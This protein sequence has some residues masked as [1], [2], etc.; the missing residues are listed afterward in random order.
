LS[1]EAEFPK[2][3]DRNMKLI[4]ECVLILI[5]ALFLFTGCATSVSIGMPTWEYKTVRL[6]PRSNDFQQRLNEAAKDRW[7]L[8]YI[9]P[10]ESLPAG[11]TLSAGASGDSEFIFERQK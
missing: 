2:S 1:V 3:E 8:Y 5:C 10:L 11:Q 9:L 4:I 6:N 7:K